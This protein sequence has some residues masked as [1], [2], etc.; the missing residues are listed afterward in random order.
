MGQTE[1]PLI[2]KPYV[3]RM[4]NSELFTLMVSGMA[5]ISGGMMVVYINYGADP[6]AVLTT[7]VMACPC[8]L[9]LAKLFL[10]E[11]STPGDGGHAAQPTIEKSPYVNAID[12]AAAGTA[13]GLRLAL[14][15]ARHADRLHR[16]RRHVRRPARRHQAGPAVARRFQPTSLAGWPDDLSLRKVFGW[17][18]SPAAFLM[19]VDAARH[20]TRSAACS[21]PSWR[22]TSTS[23]TCR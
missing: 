22:S 23:P 12:A 18:F 19:G 17:L 20:R 5:H 16:L 6:V 2:V 7:C 4:T 8:S 13:D 21:A 10:P 15:V 11:T 9:Y 3:P 14:N 1:A